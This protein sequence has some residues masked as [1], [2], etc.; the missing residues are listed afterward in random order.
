VEQKQIIIKRG[1][2]QYLYTKSE[3]Y[4]DFSLSSGALIFGHS[5][6]IFKNS[7]LSQIDNGSN[8]SSNNVNKE[9]YLKTLKENFRTL[10]NFEF[11][12]SGSEANLRALRLARAI[13]D[14]KKY[15]MVN[16]SWHG[17]IDQFLFDLKTNQKNKI[18]KIKNLSSGV[19]RSKDL[20]IL[21]YNNIELSKKILNKNKNQISVIVIEPIQC[22][23][24]NTKSIKYLKF[25]Q[26]YCM[27]KNILLWFD[28]VI[29]GMRVDKLAVFQKYSLKPDIV[30]FAKCFGGGMPIGI[31]A[32]NKKLEKIKKS[33]K[34]EV[35]FGGTFSGNPISTKVGLETF[36]YYLKNQEHIN[37][38]INNLA[39]KLEREVNDFCSENKFK[40]KL[41]RYES[42]LRP[43]FTDKNI[44]NKMQ[45]E[46]YDKNFLNSINFKNFLLSQNIFISSNCSFFISACHNTQNI[47]ILIKTIKKYLINEYS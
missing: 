15:A 6:K 46:K 24:P 42:I 26:N 34:Q 10:S 37:K 14:K 16:G 38:K 4:L 44:L 9:N 41:Q 39:Y 35:F 43:I 11:S 30:T 31:T 17:S 18:P 8:Y 12:N 20:I 45:R 13:T 5:N 21:P 3:K 22:G 33:L 32:F 47:K 40:F 23:I 27:K 36:K 19:T 29:T 28:E 25:L 2:S 7:I 1:K